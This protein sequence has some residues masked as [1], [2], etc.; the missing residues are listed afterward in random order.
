M[1]SGFPS[2]RIWTPTIPFFIHFGTLSALATV[3]LGFAATWSMNGLAPGLQW[4]RNLTCAATLLA[5]LQSGYLLVIR[6]DFSKGV[7]R[8]V[9]ASAFGAF[10]LLTAGAHLGAEQ[11]HG[12][13]LILFDKPEGDADYR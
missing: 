11:V 9:L 7:P 13:T 2:G 4:H 6:P 10:L 5:V 3:T 12:K 8:F 1:V